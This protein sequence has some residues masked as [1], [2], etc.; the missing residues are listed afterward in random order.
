MAEEA[1]IGLVIDDKY[2]LDQK[3]GEG[4]MGA[5]YLGTQ[6]MVDRHV[7]IKLLHS[8]LNEHERIKQRFEVEAKAIG[9]MHHPNCIT[10]F[11]FG[12]SAE[13]NAFYMVME[14]LHGTPMQDRVFEGVSPAEAVKITKQIA[15]ALDHAH[16]QGI[17]HRDLKPE[18]VMLTNMTD[19]SELVK[20]LDFGIARIFSEDDSPNKSSEEQNRL[21]RAGEVFGT[22][23]YIS[24]EQARGE[25][26][27]TPASDLY[28]LGVM[29]YEMLSGNLPFWGD[30]AMDTI[31]KHITDPVPPLNRLDLPKDLKDLTYALLSKKPGDRPQSGRE[32]AEL[33]D[34]A[35]L[36]PGA[37][38]TQAPANGRQDNAHAT[39]QDFVPNDYNEWAEAGATVVKSMHDIS[40]GLP[41][42]NSPHT[43]PLGAAPPVARNTRPAD[44]SFGAQRLSH[45]SGRPPHQTTNRTASTTSFAPASRPATLDELE[46]P[47]ADIPDN[48]SS[49]ML[50]GVGVVLILGI[51]GAVVLFLNIGKEPTEQPADTAEASELTTQGEQELNNIPAHPP[52]QD[53]DIVI[54]EPAVDTDAQDMAVDTPSDAEEPE[55]SKPVSKPKPKASKPKASKKEPSKTKKTTTTKTKKTTSIP[56][57][58][59]DSTPKTGKSATDSLTLGN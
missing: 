25:R 42:P 35:Q 40:T 17:L 20:V 49:T 46:D 44:P 11:D 14:Y 33:L 29:L 36:Q 12:F 19:G 45:P 57:I 34:R 59:L 58:G 26:E 52:V 9:R 21:T 55:P 22:P 53:D 1:F 24:P 10:L 32:L 18:N 15:L 56:S 51:I 3:I 43:P 28:S 48:R 5:V 23:A 38:H 50:I 31:M 30:T 8:G 13:L 6:L 27:L 4:G 7:A 47:Y 16:H 41:H 37:P 54:E 2:R 39:M